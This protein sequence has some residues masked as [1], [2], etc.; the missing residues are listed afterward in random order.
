MARPRASAEQRQQQRDLIQRAAG[1]VA[2]EKGVLGVTA[3]A[4]AVRAGVSTG[5]LYSYFANLTELLQSLWIE[6]VEKVGRQLEELVAT[7]DDPVERIRALLD[8]YVRFAED[9]P[10]V[11]RGSVLFVRPPGSAPPE[12][13]PPETLPFYRL[14]L[15]AVRDGQVGGQIAPGDSVTMAQTL[16]AGIHGAVALPVNIDRFDVHP[17][18]HLAEAMIDT[19]LNA[20]V[21]D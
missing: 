14:L 10:E 16:W 18:R 15:A 2:R 5:T 8:G 13:A 6:P 12:A 1:E 9:Q 11:F 19:L 4:V 3:R 7:I 20:I 21:V 17:A